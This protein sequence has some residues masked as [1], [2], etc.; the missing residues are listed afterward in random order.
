MFRSIENLQELG[1]VVH[2]KTKTNLNRQK[3]MLKIVFCNWSKLIRS[4]GHFH[5]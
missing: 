2:L 1:T 4:A 3:G 5:F